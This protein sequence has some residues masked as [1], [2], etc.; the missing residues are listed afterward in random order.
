MFTNDCLHICLA[1]VPP[2][3]PESIRRQ[4]VHVEEA[5]EEVLEPRRTAFEHEKEC[6][7]GSFGRGLRKR[8]GTAVEVASEVFRLELLTIVWVALTSILRLECGHAGNRR[9]MYTGGKQGKAPRLARI[10]A[11]QFLRNLR[12]RFLQWA[13]WLQAPVHPGEKTEEPPVAKLPRGSWGFRIFMQERRFE[14]GG[15][16]ENHDAAVDFVTLQLQPNWRTLAHELSWLISKFLTPAETREP[17]QGIYQ[18][19]RWR[20]RLGLAFHP[21]VWN[22]WLRQEAFV[23]K[24]ATRP[25]LKIADPQTS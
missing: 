21:R 8:F 14:T 18:M 2:H 6:V 25:S 5:A 3:T 15:T 13:K 4:S 16:L 9:S 11:S 20:P 23:S 12:C 1:A 7:L 19:S 22:I 17:C 10:S 24:R